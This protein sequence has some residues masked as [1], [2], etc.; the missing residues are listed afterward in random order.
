MV[1]KCPAKYKNLNYIQSFSEQGYATIQL[2]QQACMNDEWLRQRVLKLNYL[3]APAVRKWYRNGEWIDDKISYGYAINSNG[4]ICFNNLIEKEVIVDFI[5]D[6]EW[7]DFD[8]TD[9]IIMS[10]DGTEVTTTLVSNDVLQANDYD[11]N[12]NLLTVENDGEISGS[13]VVP[14]TPEPQIRHWCQLPFEDEAEKK[15]LITTTE[16]PVEVLNTATKTIYNKQTNSAWYV[17][18]NKKKTYYVRPDWLKNWKDKEIPS[19][20]RGQTFK[21]QSS[22][23][24]ASIDLRLDYNGTLTSDCGSPL[25]VQIWKTKKKKVVKT[26]WNKTEHKQEKVYRKHKN[27]TGGNYNKVDVKYKKVADGTGAY[28]LVYEEIQVPDTKN[29]GI[30]KPLAQAEYNPKKMESFGDV[31]IVF[32]KEVDLK[33]GNSYFIALFSPLSE[34][35]HCPR[36]GGWGR[37]CKNDEKYKYGHA[38]LS[39]D[40]GRTWIRYGRNDFEV[41]YKK[42]KYVPQDFAFKCYIRTKSLKDTLTDEDP[43]TVRDDA[44]DD[45]GADNPRYLYLKPIY[46][47][48]A[49][50]IKI[51]ADADGDSS[52]TNGKGLKYQYSIDNGVTWNNAT[53]NTTYEFNEDERPERVLVRVCLY[54]TIGNAD[55]SLDTYYNVT[56]KLYSLSV[57]LHTELPKRM[58][59]R[60]QEW[61]PRTEAMLGARIW[62]RVFSPF[63]TDPTVTCKAEIVTNDAP[64]EHFTIIETENVLSYC[65]SKVDEKD[66][67]DPNYESILKTAIND[68]K[69]LD[70][71]TPHT[72]CTYLY[73]HQDVLT[74]LKKH[75][76]YVKPY[77][78][79][80][81]ETEYLY[82][83]S[84]TPVDMGDMKILSSSE[85]QIGGIQ[86]K[87][88][89]AYPILECAYTPEGGG[90]VVNLSEGYDYT[91]D[92]DN[93]IMNLKDTVLAQMT[94]GDIGVNYNRC[95]MS[96]LSN[97]ELGVH[98]DTKTGLKEEGLILDYFKETFNINDTNVET[99]RV[100]LRVKPVDPIREVVLNRDTEEEVELYE[101]FDYNLDLDTNEIEFNVVNIDGKSSILK[102]GD[103]LEVVYTPN[104]E[105]NGLS[106]GYWCTRTNTDKQ[107][108]IKNSYWEYKA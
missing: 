15:I 59:V 92:Y 97:D 49:K 105:E 50:T 46:C 40:N 91:F 20:A 69:N 82:L 89:V 104:L 100:K 85:Y 55:P 7:I 63:E 95:F 62:G 80:D 103:V 31:N 39:E 93:N 5:N 16:K 60:T 52:A 17:G 84:F 21:A 3:T 67:N 38:F 57:T 81:S 77:R 102:T 2:M 108:R 4:E 6:D 11:E 99:R 47:N 74:E 64:T 75:N 88:D 61:K 37:N 41:P 36:W 18:F 79:N 58:Y 14:P 107:V 8:K 22:G 44:I 83:L 86:L 29:T 13:T 56:P 71:L 30:Y 33:Q 32:D 53:L 35:K 106:L 96:G 54:R 87:D 68:L 72:V 25:Y 34:W 76:I 10:Q 51:S 24:L 28:S 19:V 42:G 26:V 12:G 27:N 48:P 65:E 101:G 45:A 70:T 66:L 98:I 90:Q 1:Q 43:V 78:T 73:T 94:L 9:A 23:K